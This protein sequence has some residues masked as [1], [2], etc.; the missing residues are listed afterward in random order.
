MKRCIRHL[1]IS[2]K[3][4]IVCISCK[5]SIRKDTQHPRAHPHT[6]THKIHTY[7]H[8]HTHTHTH[9]RTV[10]QDVMDQAAA[11]LARDAELRRRT[12]VLDHI[13]GTFVAE[14][15]FAIARADQVAWPKQREC[16]VKAD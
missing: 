14:T 8:T 16:T 5:Q 6:H 15:A 4:G 11:G 13:V 9:A 7:T 2:L 12:L 10:G 3:N 1:I